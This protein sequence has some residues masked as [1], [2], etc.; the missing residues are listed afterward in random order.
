MI[1]WFFGQSDRDL[2]SNASIGRRSVRWFFVMPQSAFTQ[3][4]ASGD[5]SVESARDGSFRKLTDALVCLALAVILFRTFHVEGYKISTGSMAPC[6]IGFHKRVECPTCGHRFAFGIAYDNTGTAMVPETAAGIDPGIGDVETDD[7][8]FQPKDDFDRRTD[9]PRL[10]ATCPNCGQDSIDLTAVPS[11]QG[12]QLLVHKNVFLLRRPRRW[13]VVVFRNPSKPSQAY[14]KRIV[15]LPGE[16]VQILDGDI[17]VN[18]TIRRKNL[19]SQRAVRIPVYDHDYEPRN[20]PQWQPRWIAESAESAW[21]LV[22]H[23]FQIDTSDHLQDEEAMWSW[24]KYRHWIRAG[25]LHKTSV[26]LEVRSKGFEFPS[27]TSTPVRFDATAG[28]LSC[29]GA[30][31]DR[32]R[33][34]LLA[35]TDDPE[36][37]Q[38]IRQLHEQSHLAP[39]TDVYGYNH[40]DGSLAAMAVR[41]LMLA[42]RLTIERGQGEFVLQMTDGRHVYDCVFD[43]SA[44]QLKLTVDGKQDPTRSVP[45]PPAIAK[46]PMLVEMSLMDRQVLVAVNGRVMFAPWTDSATSAGGEPPRVPIRFAARRLRMQVDS[47]KLFRDVYYTPKGSADPYQLSQKEYYMLGD[48]SPLSYDS[49]SWPDAAVHSRLFLGKPLLVHLPSRPG[50]IKI[51]GRTTYIRIPDFSRIRYIR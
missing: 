33:D 39:I 29:R 16:T 18:G 35:M 47:L 34:R 28:R 38:A 4:R 12:D 5:S 44:D 14:V 32:W 6:L 9:T 40:S 22:A 30:L 42:A 43:L 37:T 20:D 7:A 46:K 41:D 13:E 45:L 51:G 11:N 36:F 27:L 50:K 21:Q 2:V 26:R 49:R 23:S 1:L 19:K 15:G 48:N 31:S 8:D 10:F 25:G 3:N 24:V 17:S